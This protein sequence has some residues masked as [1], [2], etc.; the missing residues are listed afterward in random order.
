MSTTVRRLGGKVQSPLGVG[1]LRVKHAHPSEGPPFAAA[2]SSTEPLEGTTYA[3][4]VEI[5]KKTPPSRLT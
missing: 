2:R 1:V 5:P 3:A 4:T